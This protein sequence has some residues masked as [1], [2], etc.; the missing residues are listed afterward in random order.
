[1]P[2]LQELALNAT[3]LNNTIT[4]LS[5]EPN[6]LRVLSVSNIPLVGSLSKFLENSPYLELLNLDDTEFLVDDEE[7]IKAISNKNCELLQL[8]SLRNCAFV[9][10]RFINFLM[11]NKPPLLRELTIT[12]TKATSRAVTKLEVTQPNLTIIFRPMN[13]TRRS[14]DI[15]FQ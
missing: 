11:G 15:Y 2:H 5:E 14:A 3:L 13:N 8:L 1:M 9:T 7:L 12:G 4:V 6:R 10:D